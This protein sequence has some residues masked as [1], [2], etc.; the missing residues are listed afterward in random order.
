[1]RERLDGNRV[2]QTPTRNTAAHSRPLARWTVSS[3]TES[4][5]GRG[6]DVEAVALVVLGGEVGEQRGQRDV[7]VDGLELRDRLDEEVEV[8]APRR[9]GGADRGGQ[10]DVDAGGVD[11]AADEVEQR[12]ADVRA[13]HPQLGGEQRE[14]LA[15]LGGVRRVARVGR[16][17]RRARRSRRGR[18]RRRSPTSWSS[19]VAALAAAAPAGESPRPAAEQPEVARA[20]RPAR[21][22]QQ[23]EQRGVGGEV[24][25]QRQHRHDL[26]DLGQPEQPG[27]ADDLDR[28]V[29]AR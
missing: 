17:R 12:L 21:P 2:S 5:A 28:H 20:D 11:D 6:R 18:C 8:V 9:G 7:A 19:T 14:A 1:M 23:R 13:Q 4:A 29:G 27:Q 10:L 25:Q 24:V 3:L 26:G 16:A 22:G 15:R